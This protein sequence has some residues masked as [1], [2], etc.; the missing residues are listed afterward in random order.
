MYG[1]TI[2]LL[3]FKFSIQQLKECNLSWKPYFKKNS[4]NIKYKAVDKKL[5]KIFNHYQ[6]PKE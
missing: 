1:A 5:Y 6:Y 3:I 2:F 4:E